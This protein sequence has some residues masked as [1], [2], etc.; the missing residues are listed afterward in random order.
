MII[1]NI[2]HHQLFLIYVWSMQIYFNVREMIVC[3][4]TKNTV[5]TCKAF[6]IPLKG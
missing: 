3:S 4:A 5:G 2:W 6:D 1:K